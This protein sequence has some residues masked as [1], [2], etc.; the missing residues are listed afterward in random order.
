M[1]EITPGIHQLKLPMT[2]LGSTLGHVNSYLIQGDNGYL[3]VDTTVNNDE[4]FDSLLKQLAEIGADIRDISQIMVT[5]LH[6]DHYG[7]AGRI[8]QLSGAT[9]ILNELEKE[10]IESRYINM[11]KLLEQTADWLNI[12][13]APPDDL[14]DMRDATLELK[15][16]VVPTYP[17]FTLHGGETIATG[18]FTF[19]ALWTPGHT[20]GH[21]CLYEAEKNILIS[22]DHILPTITPNVSKHPQAIDNPLGKYL[23]S[24]DELKKLGIELVLPGHENPF[25]PLNPRIDELIQHHEERMDEILLALKS[26]PET[27]Y[28]VARQI[29]WKDSVGWDDMPSPHRRLAMFET[30]AHLELMTIKGQTDKIS[31]DSIIY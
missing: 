22:G 25:S 6:P 5:H 23:D 9:F 24:L 1:T 31:R 4:S 16:Y 27:A 7:M 19:Q 21:T 15:R 11:D 3:L 17:D 18:M 12:N 8:K 10:F 14:A 20:S 13:G 26:K 30:I 2:M 29:T 28:Q